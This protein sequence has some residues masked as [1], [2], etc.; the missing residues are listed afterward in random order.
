M[1]AILWKSHC[2][3]CEY[4]GGTPWGRGRKDVL[5][6]CLIISPLLCLTVHWFFSLQNWKPQLALCSLARARRVHKL[7]GAP[8]D[9]NPELSSPSTVLLQGRHQKFPCIIPEI[10]LGLCTMLLSHMPHS[11]LT[12]CNS[13]Y[14][15]E[16]YD[17]E[18]TSW[19]G[20][21]SALPFTV[22]TANSWLAKVPGCSF[23][24]V[25]TFPQCLQIDKWYDNF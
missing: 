17:I 22:V 9:G 4:E 8:A 2:L 12:N 16:S 11:A 18:N 13:Y 25:H 6:L 1:P 21:Q 10:F 19:G 20:E 23:K 24:M 5:T 7:S 15:R 14:T 3:N